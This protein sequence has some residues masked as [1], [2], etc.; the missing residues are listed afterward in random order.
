MLRAHGAMA[1]LGRM[2]E[3]LA[4]ENWSDESGR[5]TKGGEMESTNLG[6]QTSSR[7]SLA[8][9]LA[10]EELRK[11]RI[12]HHNS[13]HVFVC[14]RL[15]T[16]MWLEQLHKAADIL[17]SIPPGHAAWAAAMFKSLLTGILFPFIRQATQGDAKNIRSG[18]GTAKNVT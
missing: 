15:M 13:M 2:T 1:W 7:E 17:L 14:P 12:K 16:P 9:L 8:A 10:L 18:W 6:N 4:L 11:A 5:N 3:T